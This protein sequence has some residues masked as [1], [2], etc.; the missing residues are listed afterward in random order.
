MGLCTLKKLASQVCLPCTLFLPT[1]RGRGRCVNLQLNY[2]EF[3]S[4]GQNVVFPGK[5]LISVEGCLPPQGSPIS[6]LPAPEFWGKYCFS[7]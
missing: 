2:I 6:F 7:L 5:L 4:S 3:K 1:A